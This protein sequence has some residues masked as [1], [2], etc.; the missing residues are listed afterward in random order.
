MD[1]LIP[2]ILCSALASFFWQSAN[3]FEKD[4]KPFSAMLFRAFAFVLLGC[5]MFILLDHVIN[6]SHQAS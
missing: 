4:D 5:G 2:I 6:L 1:P 3:A